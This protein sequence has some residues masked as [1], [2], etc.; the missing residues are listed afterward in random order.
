MVSSIFFFFVSAKRSQPG[1]IPALRIIWNRMKQKKLTRNFGSVASHV[2]KNGMLSL[3]VNYPCSTT[4]PGKNMQSM[5]PRITWRHLNRYSCA[6]G[7]A[8]CMQ[9]RP[10]ALLSCTENQ[11]SG[12]SLEAVFGFGHGWWSDWYSVVDLTQDV[13]FRWQIHGSIVLVM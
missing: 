1:D 7:F 8:S 12:L 2:V 5:D 6:Q 9:L 10:H 4:V 11:S 13:R 3:S